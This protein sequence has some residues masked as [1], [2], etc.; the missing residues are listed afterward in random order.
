M[1]YDCGEVEQKTPFLRNSDSSLSV[2]TSLYAAVAACDNADDRMIRAATV[3]M[4][5]IQITSIFGSCNGLIYFAENKTGRFVVSNPLRSQFTI[6]PPT[7]INIYWTS[8]WT[9][10]GLVFLHGFLHWMM[11]S[12]CGGRILAFDVSKET[13]KVIPHPPISFK[14]H[15]RYFRILDFNG[16]LGMLD[17][18]SSI[19]YDIWV[20]DHEK[21]SWDKQYTIDITVV[22]KI[23]LHMPEVIGPWK[24]DQILF[25][26]CDQ[27]YNPFFVKYW[28][29]SMRTGSIK[30]CK[31]R[32]SNAQV[33]CLKG[34]LISVPGAAEVS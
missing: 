22:G 5:N 15:E 13:F 3:R 2:N 18:S 4:P 27:A 32:S 9:A 17:L 34:S 21:I 12:S 19:K 31:D 26:Y 14:E 11:D 30:E 1:Q 33:Y 20:M 7:P 25:R 6:L 10:I 8:Y 28:S 16:N 24:Q 29:Y 23:G